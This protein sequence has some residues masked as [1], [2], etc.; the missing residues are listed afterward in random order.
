M[1]L[2]WFMTFVTTL[3]TFAFRFLYKSTKFH[4]VGVCLGLSIAVFKYFLVDHNFLS[5]HSS[6]L[7]CVISVYLAVNICL[8][9]SR[10]SWRHEGMRRAQISLFSSLR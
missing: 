1:Q 6:F 9:M 4:Q 8:Y 3:T 2:L 7:G 10:C 5:K